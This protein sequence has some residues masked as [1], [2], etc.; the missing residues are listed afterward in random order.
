MAA[1]VLQETPTLGVRQQTMGRHT[2]VRILRS[3]ETPWGTVRVKV[4]V[5]NGRPVA[6]SP[7]YDDC[8]RLAEAAGVPLAEVMAAAR[9]VGDQT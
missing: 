8:A 6:A 1:I 7:E 2:A 4:K 9:L 3:V 5:L